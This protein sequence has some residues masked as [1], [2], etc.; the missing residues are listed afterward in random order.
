[1]DIPM[2]FAMRLISAGLVLSLGGLAVAYSPPVG[3]QS[4]TLEVTSDTAEYCLRLQNRLS[5]LVQVSPA[6]PP[7]EV[8]DLSTQGQRMC[9][10]GQTRGGIMRL[11]RAWVLMTH[12][13]PA[14]ASS[15]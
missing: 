11:R 2:S 15:P 6:P 4:S 13:E 10:Q 12:P 1:M 3:A 8:A 9:G 5:D 7:P 14:P